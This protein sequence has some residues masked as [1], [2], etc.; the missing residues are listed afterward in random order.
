MTTRITGAF[1]PNRN[2]TVASREIGG[3]AVLLDGATGTLLE[4]NPF[5]SIV[6]SCLDGATSIDELVT[7]LS[8]EFRASPTRVRR[9]VVHLVHELHTS[10]LLDDGGR[11][12]RSVP[13]LK[14]SLDRRT[15]LFLAEP[16]S[17]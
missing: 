1:A 3:G 5:A 14:Q 10:G 2:R 6:W 4:L 7:D 16:P 15:A 12:S 11:R 8:R 13:M 17:P 9:D